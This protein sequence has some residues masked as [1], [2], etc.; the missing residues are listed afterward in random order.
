MIALK[1]VVTICDATLFEQ[2]SL[3]L[4]Q[5]EFLAQISFADIILVNKADLVKAESLDEAQ[6]F[7]R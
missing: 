3:I 1:G 2:K 5:N 7:V 4:Q 6:K